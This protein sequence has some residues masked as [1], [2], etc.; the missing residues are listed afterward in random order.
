MTLKEIKHATQEELTQ[1][2]DRIASDF[3]EYIN[4]TNEE[5]RFRADGALMFLISDEE[6]EEDLDESTELTGGVSVAGETARIAAMLLHSE[7]LKHI[8]NAAFKIDAITPQ[9]EEEDE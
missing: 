2:L 7:G 8:T 6:D 5:S 9:K 3:Y 4:K 1:E